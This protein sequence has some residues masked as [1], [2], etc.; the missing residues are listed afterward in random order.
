MHD[1]NLERVGILT[2]G[3]DCPGLNAVIRA[4]VK[5]A[6]VDYGIEV[7]GIKDG[8]DG[9]VR[10]KMVSLTYD[11]AS[12]ILT[13]GGTILGA[14]N[15]ANPFN[16]HR[17][18]DGAADPV[19]ASDQCVD[20]FHRHQLDALICIGGDGTMSIAQRL[21]EKGLPAVGVPKTIDND[22]CETDVT[23][24]FDTATQI[25]ADALDR[26]HTT[27]QSHHRVMVIETMGRYV[28]WLALQGGM[29]GGGD[30]ILIPEIDY[31]MDSICRTVEDRQ[32]SG[33]NFSIVVVSEG[34]K[35]PEGEYVARRHV[36][37]STDTMRLG[38]IG[39]WLA[40]A[41]EDASGV[42]SRSVVLGHLQRGGTPT[43]RDRV[44]ATRF[45][46]NAMVSAAE[47]NF[48]TMVA[49]QGNRIENVPLDRVANRQRAVDP[50]GDLVRTARS[51]GTCFGDR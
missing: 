25:V 18:E 49:L 27:A 35:T 42:E 46:R 17:P 41:I 12:G 36:E 29:A 30:I 19:D 44:L 20:N 14:S 4:V 40:N 15:K 37:E 16:Y 13:Q 50:D 28:G 10:D 47:H 34:V 48:G 6:V 1:G 51:V 38:G 5:T 24:G 39:E 7:T 21:Q 31:N 11:D 23:F 32:H 2:G 43:A 8:Y 26:L 9:L 33:R 22:V 3:G 45:G